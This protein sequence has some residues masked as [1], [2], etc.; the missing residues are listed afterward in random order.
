MK[1]SKANR[2]VFAWPHLLVGV[3]AASAAASRAESLPSD[4]VPTVIV[5]TQSEPVAPGK[6]E[7][8]WESLRQYDVPEW[9]RDAKFGIWAHWGPQCQ[10]EAGDWYAR[11]MYSQGRGQYDAHMQRYGHPSEYGFK[12][13]IHDWKADKWDPDRLVGLYKRVGAQYF[14][15]M[16]NHHDNLDMW[17]SR[18]Q[19]WNSV[20]VGPKKDLIAGWAK[21]ARENGLPFGVSAHA[22]HAWSWYEVAQGADTEGDKAGAPYDGNLTKAD[23]KGTWWEGLDPQDLY[24]QAHKPSPDFANLNRIHWRW[25]WNND[26]TLPDQAYCEKFYNRTMD[27]INK[28]QPELIYFDDTALPLWPVSDAGLKLAAHFY[29]TNLRK[30]GGASNGVLFGKVLSDDQKEALT[31]DVERG[32]PPTMEFPAWQT[33]TCLGGWHYDRGVYQQSRYKSAKAV[34]H[35]LADIVS[36]NGNLLLSVPVRGDGSIDEKEEAILE[37]IASWMEVNREA[38]LATRP[39][40]V[41]G[42]G[43]ASEGAPIHAQGFNEGKGKPLTAEDIRYTTSKDGATLYAIVMGSP[44]EPVSLESLGAEAGLLERR[45]ERVELLGSGGAADWEQTAERLVIRTLPAANPSD[46]DPTAPDA[47]VYKLTL[48]N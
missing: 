22:A 30:T 32:V 27:L 17:D 31:W 15:A 36:K 13:V 7:P 35:M 6:F 44:V 33:C 46:A 20:A 43:P 1:L 37:S 5:D 40:K 2:R 8:T 45:V 16:A 3:L 12:D 10:P 48:A 34:V 26:V 29:N 42:E 9:Y 4:A 25:T 39:W 24:A 21:A 11:H 47:V 23:G 38:I 18:H 41:F 28:H 19:P 14:F